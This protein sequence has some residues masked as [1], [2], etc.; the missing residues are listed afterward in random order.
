[1]LL[2]TSSWFWRGAVL[3]GILPH[4]PVFQSVSR[5]DFSGLRN[6]EAVAEAEGDGNFVYGCRRRRRC[7]RAIVPRPAF[8]SFPKMHGCTHS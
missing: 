5:T 1:M 4:V 6:K 3:S 8:P 7:M 2:P